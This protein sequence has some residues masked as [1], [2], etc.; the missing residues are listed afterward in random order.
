MK[1][2]HVDEVM[3]TR[4][5]LS[6]RKFNESRFE[7]DSLDS[8]FAIACYIVAVL[9]ALMSISCFCILISKFL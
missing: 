3:M 7:G 1:L 2:R 6:L 5:N 4:R 9:M 8:G